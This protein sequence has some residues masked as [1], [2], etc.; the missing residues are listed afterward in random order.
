MAVFVIDPSVID[1]IWVQG[2]SHS[3]FERI[4]SEGAD[5]GIESAQF[6]ALSDITLAD[7]Q[8]GLWTWEVDDSRF[9]HIRA[10][11]AGYGLSLSN[12]DR[13]RVDDLIVV[14]TTGIHPLNMHFCQDVL[15]TR[16]WVASA[17]GTASAVFVRGSENV[18][19]VDLVVAGSAQGLTG[20]QSSG[21][22]AMGVTAFGN[23]GVHP[24]NAGLRTFHAAQSVFTDVLTLGNTVG[25]TLHNSSDLHIEDVVSADNEAA[26]LSSM[27][28]ATAISGRFALQPPSLHDC[29]YQD[30]TGWTFDCSLPQLAT[31][32]LSNNADGSGLGVGPVSSDSVN[33]SSGVSLTKDQIDDW[34]NFEHPHRG[35]AGPW[36]A[37]GPCDA[38]TPC[39][40]VDVSLSLG[41]TG[42]AGAPLALGVNP[43]PTGNDVL[44]LPHGTC[45]IAGHATLSHENCALAGGNWTLG[46]PDRFLRDA[47]ELL[48][49]GLGDDDGLCES[50][51][52]CL[53]MPNIGAYQGHGSLVTVPFVDGEISGVAMMQHSL[54][55]R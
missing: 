51:E 26:L 47:T 46:S 28:V 33:A 44:E 36:G 40:L 18:R 15:V 19:F 22:L 11:R 52:A 24:W 8:Y 6:L 4:H 5:F 31:A 30:S 50:A 29:F 49:D 43:V 12:S 32:D 3:R 2:G 17:E 39:T 9:D 54:N 20:H 35:W 13:I 41:D 45:S 23:G 14:A 42:L 34:W 37:V 7:S 38:T 53:H 21:T 10:A 1:T 55:G 48:D 27:D 25:V 16:A